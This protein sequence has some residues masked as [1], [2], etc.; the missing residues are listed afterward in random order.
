[1][2]RSQ[3]ARTVLVVG[4]VYVACCWSGF[5]GFF[6]LFTAVVALCVVAI[7]TCVA[8]TAQLMAPQV[9]AY[10]IPPA[11]EFANVNA[12]YVQ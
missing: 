3:N 1:M 4:S 10:C 6:Y 9:L 7:I 12:R 8:F 2:D 5:V 11:T